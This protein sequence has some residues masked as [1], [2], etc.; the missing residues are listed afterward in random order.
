MWK[1]FQ[2]SGE[3][4]RHE[5]GRKLRTALPSEA[6]S[7]EDGRIEPGSRNDGK[8]NTADHRATQVRDPDGRNGRELAE[9]TPG[10]GPVRAASQILERSGWRPQTGILDCV[11]FLLQLRQCRKHLFAVRSWF[12]AHENFSDVAL[13][14]NDERVASR[15]LV[16]VVLHH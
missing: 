15:Q 6:A 10:S 7:V 9:I 11:L 5:A 4:Q 13:R 12:H 1:Y 16:S 14:I 2:G 3:R 8:P